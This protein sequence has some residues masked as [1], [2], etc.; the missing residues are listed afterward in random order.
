MAYLEYRTSVTTLAQILNDSAAN[1]NFKFANQKHQSSRRKL[2]IGRVQ[3]SL[4]LP[5]LKCLKRRANSHKITAQ[6]IKTAYL[7]NFQVFPFR[8]RVSIV[9]TLKI[10]IFKILNEQSCLLTPFHLTKNT[11]KW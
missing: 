6:I 9:C 3:T 1:Q 4:I 11:S 7:A 5:T 10:A 8:L 2:E